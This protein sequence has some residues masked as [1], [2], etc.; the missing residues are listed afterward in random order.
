MNSKPRG[1]MTRL[2]I[3]D[4]ETS[5]LVNN[6][7]DPSYNIHTGEYCQ[8]VS[9]G[10]IVVNADTFEKI[11]ELYLEIKWDGK[12][13]WDKKAEAIHGLSKEYLEKHGMTRLEAVE[14][15]GNLIL[16]HWGP[17]SPVHIG[18]HNPSFDLCFLKRDL[19]SEGLE[20]KFGHKQVDTNSIGL[21]VYGTYNSDDLFEM[22]GMAPRQDHNALDDARSALRVM[23]QTRKL[24]DVC[25]G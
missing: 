17:S 3:I 22:V 14:Q 9:W 15:I 10:M 20:V 7:D 23:Q 4:G 19:R 13:I 1:Y 16:D 24:A 2:L 11:D 25:L 18:G 21:V 12:S 8:T 5:G 6:S